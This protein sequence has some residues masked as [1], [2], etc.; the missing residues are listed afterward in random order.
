MA[1]QKRLRQQKQH[2]LDSQVPSGVGAGHTKGVAALLAAGASANG[3]PDLNFPPIVYAA[4]LGNTSMVSLLVDHGADVNIGHTPL[5][6]ICKPHRGG[7]DERVVALRELLE[8]GG[9]ASLADKQL[10]KIMRVVCADCSVQGWKRLVDRVLWVLRSL[11][12][13]SFDP[14]ESLTS[15]WPQVEKEKREAERSSYGMLPREKGAPTVSGL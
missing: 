10:S 2:L 6:A 13:F 11:H 1:E 12:L 3:S 14:A 5:M 8:A 7:A 9:D 15:C 4:G